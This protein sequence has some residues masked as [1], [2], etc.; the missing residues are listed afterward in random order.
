MGDSDTQLVFTAQGEIESSQ[1]KTR[2][3]PRGPSKPKLGRSHS[4]TGDVQKLEDGRVG[5]EAKRLRTAPECMSCS[6]SLEDAAKMTCTGCLGEVCLTCSKLPQRVLELIKTGEVTG[7]PW[8]CPTCKHN[9][10]TM[11]KME[12]TLNDIK[13]TNSERMSAIEG[14]LDEMVE[15]M[16]KKIKEKVDEE[17]PKMVE[18]VEKSVCNTVTERLNVIENKVDELVEEKMAKIDKKMK[19]A[20]TI[21]PTGVSS[22]ILKQKIKEAVQEEVKAQV[23]DTPNAQAP[24]NPIS[25]GTQIKQTIASVTAELKD[26]D[27]RKR[28]FVVY[29]VKEVDTN[30]KEERVT[31]DKEMVVKICKDVLKVTIATTDLKDARRMGEKID[32]KS[33]PLKICLASESTKE[34]IFKKLVRLRGSMYDNLTFTHDMTKMEREHKNKM[35][36]EARVL[37]AKDGGKWR[38]RVRGPPWDMKIVKLER[39]NM[40]EQNTETPMTT[41]SPAKGGGH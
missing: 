33:R 24:R 28:N 20:S 40:T 1:S 2:G 8:M 4:L 14:K 17:I 30:L 23:P 38:Y 19:E 29:G 37:E 11:R 27:E 10:P 18:T 15:T 35:V 9:L 41:N 32:T 5:R 25:P 21:E 26:R 7:I 36:A 16:D 39:L 3:R 22:P 12:Q 13:K 34:S 31:H 6:T